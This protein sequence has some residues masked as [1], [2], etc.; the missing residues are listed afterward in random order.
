V[1]I[2]LVQEV[3]Q[4]QNRLNRNMQE[5]QEKARDMISPGTQNDSYAMAKVEKALIS[6]ME[7]QVNEHIKLLKPMKDR[8]V[9]I[10]MS[11][12]ISLPLTGVKFSSAIVKYLCKVLIVCVVV[13]KTR[14]QIYASMDRYDNLFS[15]V[16]FVNFTFFM[17]RITSV[18]KNYQ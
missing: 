5:C 11:L 9:L 12:C 13:H 8:Y 3:A 10:G 16:C 6:C 17:C 4:F 15:P 18:L 14:M 1:K 2:K 7:T